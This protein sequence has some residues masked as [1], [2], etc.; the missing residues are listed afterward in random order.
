MVLQAAQLLTEQVPQLPIPQPGYFYLAVL[1]EVG[2][3]LARAAL[4]QRPPFNLIL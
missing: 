3:Q 2:V 4:S 1:E